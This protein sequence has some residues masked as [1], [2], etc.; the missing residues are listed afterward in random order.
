MKR[1]V[2]SR[3]AGA[4]L[5]SGV[6]V[7]TR[8]TIR[9]NPWVGPD[10]VKAYRRFVRQVLGGVMCAQL[11]ED[12][13]DVERRFTRPIEEWKEL[14]RLLLP[15]SQLTYDVA[16]WCPLDNPCHADVWIEVANGTHNDCL[17]LE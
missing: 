1:F 3:K 4:T 12:G 13:L 15:R 14:R 10:C 9:G 17:Q 5:P 16:C 2:R 7:V 8:P 6:V 11:C